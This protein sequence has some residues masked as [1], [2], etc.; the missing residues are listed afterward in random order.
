MGAQYA[1]IKADPINSEFGNRGGLGEYG[2][3]YLFDN[4]FV[5]VGFGQ[6]FL[7]LRKFGHYVPKEYFTGNGKDLVKIIPDGWPAGPKWMT[8]DAWDLSTDSLWVPEELRGVD[9]SFYGKSLVV[10]YLKRTSD[11][12]RETVVRVQMQPM[13]TIWEML[14]RKYVLKMERYVSKPLYKGDPLLES[15]NLKVVYTFE[16]SM[17]FLKY[18]LELLCKEGNGSAMNKHLTNQQICD[19]LKPF[20]EH[21][22]EGYL[23]AEE[24]KRS[25]DD[26]SR[27]LD[28]HMSAYWANDVV[29][30]AY[31][32]DFENWK[33]GDFFKQKLHKNHRAPKLNGV[34]LY[35]LQDKNYTEPQDKSLRVEPRFWVGFI[36]EDGE[37]GSHPRA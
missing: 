27:Y 35:G 29:D 6:R 15:E 22:A 12:H 9:N 30:P 21:S 5:D 24:V 18:R 11:G 32:Q 19:K 37:A 4:E 20:V 16:L 28:T 1:V 13:D 14:F 2:R 23:E 7:A 31:D 8:E 25:Y 26:Y 17:A 34:V 10:Y 33:T 36:T 3:E